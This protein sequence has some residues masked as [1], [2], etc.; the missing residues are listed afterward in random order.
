MK[1]ELKQNSIFIS[2]AH[3]NSQRTELL[4]FLRWV[5]T[6]NFAQIFFMGDIFDFLS[7]ESSY[8]I[9]ENI[10]LINAINRLSERFE[11]YYFEGNHDFNLKNIFTTLTI[12]SRENQPVIFEFLNQ[13]IAFS[14]GDNFI[15]IGYDIFSK[16]IRN[17]LFLKLL[18]FIDFEF[19]LSKKIKRHLESKNI[20][21]KYK[22]NEYTIMSKVNNI[23]ADIISEGHFHQDFSQ[24]IEDKTYINFPAFACSK[25][26]CEF[27]D[28]KFTSINITFN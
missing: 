8:F 22:I 10:E 9:Q 7:G 18:N 25:K 19:W 21:A 12:F 14:H 4:D 11:V 13:K 5:E 16:I 20:C 26:V 15:G 28:G 3:F 6:Q 27:R 2:D 17:H 23:Y 1:L 24:Q